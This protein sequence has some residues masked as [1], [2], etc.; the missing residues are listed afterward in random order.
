MFVFNQTIQNMLRFR[1]SHIL[2][3][4]DRLKAMLGTKFELLDFHLVETFLGE[5]KHLKI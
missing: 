4:K 1:C 3:S 2:Q 5:R